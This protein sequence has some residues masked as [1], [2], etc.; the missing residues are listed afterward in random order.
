MS[1]IRHITP[2]VK[3]N[4]GIQSVQILSKNGATAQQDVFQL[5][6]QIAPRT[7]QDNLDIKWK[8]AHSIVERFDELLFRIDV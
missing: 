4:L 3:D 1:A 2:A 8:S 7:K 6:F 5:H